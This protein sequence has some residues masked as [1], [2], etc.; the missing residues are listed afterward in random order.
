[1]YSMFALILLRPES[2]LMP[3]FRLQRMSC[4]SSVIVSPA[5][6]SVKRHCF[7]GSPFT[8]REVMMGLASCP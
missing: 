5:G 2:S 6:F 8:T 4:W 7:G 3:V 1:M